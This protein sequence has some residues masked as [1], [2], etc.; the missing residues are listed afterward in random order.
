MY[1]LLDQLLINFT[2]VYIYI[3]IYEC[4]HV[5]TVYFTIIHCDYS[6]CE[7]I[8]HT[9]T[10]ANESQPLRIHKQRQ[11]RLFLLRKL[12]CFPFGFSLLL[13]VSVGHTS[14][15]KYATVLKWSGVSSSLHRI[16]VCGV[17]GFQV[18]ESVSCVVSCVALWRQHNSTTLHVISLIS[19]SHY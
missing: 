11:Q 8:A 3:F 17:C 10:N 1:R 2:N 13:T 5:Y 16:G 14:L 7:V 15:S 19:L 9:Q 4:I 6:L 18:V 12:R